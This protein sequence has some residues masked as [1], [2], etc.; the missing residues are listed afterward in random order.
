M[1][2]G[3]TDGNSPGH[4]RPYGVARGDDGDRGVDIDG[5]QDDV[6]RGVGG[7]SANGLVVRPAR[8]LYDRLD[9]GTPGADAVEYA[10]S[11]GAMA[12]TCVPHDGDV[13]DAV[14]HMMALFFG[15]EYSLDTGSNSRS[16][17]LPARPHFR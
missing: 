5:R 4:D 13:I 16:P 12:A 7:G 3:Q 11:P 14:R 6:T 10:A 8:P 1:I 17:L 9:S 15:T 2:A